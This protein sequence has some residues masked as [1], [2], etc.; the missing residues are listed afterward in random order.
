MKKKTNTHGGARKGAGRP[1]G[2]GT[3][4]KSATKSITMTI[5]A[6]EKIDAR[7]G[8]QTRG[9]YIATKI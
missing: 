6:W 5:K 3:G 9:A 8:D 1:E 2:T 7:R 4:R